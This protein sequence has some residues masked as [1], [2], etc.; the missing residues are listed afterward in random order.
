MRRSRRPERSSTCCSEAMRGRPF[1]SLRSR[2]TGRKTFL[3]LVDTTTACSPEDKRTRRSEEHT[4]ELQSQFHL[5]FRLLL[6]KKN[7][8]SSND[9]CYIQTAHIH[10]TLISHSRT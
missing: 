10:T 7:T 5:V 6:Q 3:G 8:N 9:Q 2:T 1:L 4:S